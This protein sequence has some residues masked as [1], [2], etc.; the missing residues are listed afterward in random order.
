MNRVD[1]LKILVRHLITLGIVPNQKGLGEILGYKN[2]SYFSQIINNK[3]PLPEDFINKI[4]S[5][6]ERI[7]EHWLIKGTGEML[8]DSTSQINNSGEFSNT[9]DIINT[10]TNNSTNQEYLEIIKSLTA[11][12]AVSQQQVSVSQEQMNRLITIIENK[13]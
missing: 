3:V 13:L 6:D 9:G 5:L 2:E 4:K 7:N 1:R 10:V 11:Q 12:L 8:I